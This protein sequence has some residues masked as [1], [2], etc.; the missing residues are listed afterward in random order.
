METFIQNIIP[1]KTYCFPVNTNKFNCINKVR[2]KVFVYYKRRKPEELLFITQFLELHNIEY[3]V[4]DYLKRYDENDY[5]SY[6]QESKYGIIVDAHESQGFAIEEA[7]SC[8]VPLLVWDVRFMSQ[9]Y[10]SRYP[11]IPAT[12]VPYFDESCGKIFHDQ[13]EF[14]QTYDNFMNNINNYNPREYIM[15]NLSYDICYKKFTELI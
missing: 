14:I 6:L 1:V 11:D 7:L 2:D 15:D 10:R 5:I 4:F 12:T 13:E 3:K 9:E 8:N